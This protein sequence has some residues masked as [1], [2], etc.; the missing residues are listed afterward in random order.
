VDTIRSR[1]GGILGG[2]ASGRTAHLPDA[3]A[4][5]IGYSAARWIGRREGD[6]RRVPL[7]QCPA[8][9]LKV[10]RASLCVRGY[11]PR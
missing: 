4:V 3:Q 1:V 10:L 2:E 8:A 11:E 9:A 5:A 6:E 7:P